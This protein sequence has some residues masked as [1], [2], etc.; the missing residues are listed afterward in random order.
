MDASH[1]ALPR[2]AQPSGHSR[3]PLPTI[4]AR[5]LVRRE[6][7]YLLMRC[8]V[9]EAWAACPRAH[10][11]HRTFWAGLT[12]NREGAKN[13]IEAQERINPP[14]LSADP[15][16]CDERKPLSPGEVRLLDFFADG[17]EA[18]HRLH[19]FEKYAIETYGV[20]QALKKLCDG[21]RDPKIPTFAVVNSLLHAAVLRLPSLNTLE[22][23]LET[24]EFQKLVGLRPRKGKRAISA[25]T[26]ADVLDTLDISQL[27]SAVVDLIKKAERNKAFRDDTFGI[28]RT[29]ALD[30]WEPFCTYERHCEGCLTRQV[31]RKVRNDDGEL[32]E[33]K[34][35]QY[36]HRF[37]VAFLI[38]PKLD[39]TLAIEPV[40]SSDLRQELKPKQARHEGELTAALRLID[41]LHKQYGRFIDAFTLDGLYPCGPV[42]S[43]LQKY[44]YGAFIITKNEKHDPYRFAEEIWRTRSGPDAVEVDPFTNEKVE[45]WE[46]DDVDALSSFNG[47]VKM[48]KAVVTRKNGK[49]STWVMAILGKAKKA[50]RLMALRIMRARWHIENT[51]FHQWVTKWNLDH[52]YRHTNNAI[53][54]V[55][56]IWTLA[57]NLMQLFFYRRLKKAR[58]GRHSTDTIKALVLNMFRDLA[59]LPAPVPWDAID[60]SC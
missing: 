38:A 8:F 60:D 6:S 37:V 4:A 58:R 47:S 25:D 32:V 1:H 29:V 54:A 48:L 55:L 59:Y 51:A 49:K 50:S 19:Q 20:P 57:F 7:G 15:K 39:M 9:R 40:L 43:K 24:T 16:T 56:H 11:P 21:R 14:G 42:L 23:Q 5:L 53:T 27:E 33:E 2:F 36:Y 31:K 34:V 30:G 45:F 41:R 28:F 17:V 46:V 3:R 18:G 22:Q 12:G 35:T 52:C 13:H 44:R 26:M 10:G